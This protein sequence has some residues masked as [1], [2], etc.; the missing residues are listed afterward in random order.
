M[1]TLASLG[2]LLLSLP[3]AAQSPCGSPE[4]TVTVSPPIAAPGEIVSVT[5]T[6]GSDRVIV[7]PSS[8][9]FVSVHSDLACTTWVAT[10]SC[11]TINVEIG[12]GESC[13][14]EWGQTDD[15]G[16]QVPDGTYTFGVWYSDGPNFVQ[17]CAAG[18]TVTSE[19]DSASALVRNGSGS[20]PLTLASVNPPGLGE[21]WDTSLDCTGHA[22]ATAALV[23]HGSPRTGPLTSFG[24]VLVG[25]PRI[26]RLVQPHA[27]S[28][29]AF[30]QPVPADVTLCGLQVYSQGSCSG[31]PGL[32][33][34][35][36]LDLVVGF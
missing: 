10:R 4:I 23:V 29:V 8:C 9:T 27:G 35:N 2:L 34:S 13:T 21:S 16:Q 30:S 18:V 6:N 19:C 28:A 22:P 11:L 5:L 20:N 24:E 32:Q 36:A 26:L 3:V 1:R 25:G 15:D 17:C 33:L 14:E 7:L 31:A 12:P